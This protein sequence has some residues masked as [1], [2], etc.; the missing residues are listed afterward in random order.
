VLAFYRREL[1]KREWKEQAD[2]A[3]VKSDKVMLAFASPDGPAL[4]KLSRE[5][6]ETT[7]SI[8]VKNPERGGKGRRTAVPRHGQGRAR[9]FR[10][11]G[12]F[13]DDRYRRRSSSNPSSRP[14]QSRVGRC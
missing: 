7:I 2:G 3:I 1:T 14:Q 9:Q 11:D 13:G 8:V 4:L 6:K 10:R 5:S 12:S